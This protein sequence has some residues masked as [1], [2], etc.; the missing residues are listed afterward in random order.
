[1]T[2]VEAL[3][4]LMHENGGVASWQYIYDNIERYY[5]NIKAPKDWESAVRGVLYREIYNN[6]SFK[7]VG[8]G[9]YGLI[10]FNEEKA[11]TIAKKDKVRMHSYMEGVM[12]ELGNYEKFA[13]YCADPSAQFQDSI[14]IS[15]LTTL[16]TFPAFT[17]TEI[18]NVA[19]RIDVIWFTSHGYQFPRRVV[20]I[21]DSIGTLGESLNRMYQL[22]D[23]STD[24]YVLAPKQYRNKIENTLNRE[25]YSIHKERFI[26]KSYEEALDYYKARIA[27]SKAQF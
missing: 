12:V 2:K 5:P 27:L 21:V 24:F 10:D 1:M 3:Q 26:V 9:I 22:K 16:A 11:L 17:Y 8:L 14:S 25:P 13:T 7:K 19:K 15:Q 4:Q 18:V 6:R 20:E 23:F